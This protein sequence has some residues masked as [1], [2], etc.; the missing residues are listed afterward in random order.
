M[1]MLCMLAL[2]CKTLPIFLPG[3]FL[4]FESDSQCGLL[5]YFLFF[6]GTE[7]VLAVIAMPFQDLPVFLS[8]FFPLDW[9]L[10][11]LTGLN[12]FSFRLT[13]DNAELEAFMEACV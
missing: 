4:M 5:L 8:A 13:F 6:L 3:F 12:T 9:P 7:F 10:I 2:I 1:L 11:R